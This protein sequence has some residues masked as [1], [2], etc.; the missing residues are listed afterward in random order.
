M[1]RVRFPQISF[2]KDT[3]SIYKSEVSERDILAPIPVGIVTGDIRTRLMAEYV[4]LLIEGIA[5]RP[6]GLALD[7]V[8][9]SLHITEVVEYFELYLILSDLKVIGK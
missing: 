7:I 5:A 9:R 4:R 6:Q 2:F 8:V 3:I 1:H